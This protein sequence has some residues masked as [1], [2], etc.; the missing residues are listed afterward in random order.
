MDN[1]KR[2]TPEA[3]REQIIQAALA[4]FIDKGFSGTTTA[5]LPKQLEFLK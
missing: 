3:R 1:V 4:V 2:L 5:E